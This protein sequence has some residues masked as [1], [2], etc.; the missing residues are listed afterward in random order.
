KN[1]LLMVAENRGPK[2]NA[3]GA[4]CALR[5]EYEDGTDE[6]IMTDTTWEV[7]GTMP[8]GSRPNQWKLD[9]LS[10]TDPVPV[11]V[12][13]WKT[14]TD[15]R[16][17]TTL[18]RA[19]AGS[20]RLIRASLLKAD[21]L[22]RALG[23]PNRDQIVTSRPAELTTLEAVHLATSD[24]LVL[25]LEEGAQR[26]AKLG[27]TTRLVEEIYLSTLSRFPTASEES[28]AREALG[29]APR[30]ESITD[31]LWALAMTPEFLIVR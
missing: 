11:H 1:T 15:K 19:S 16:I 29:E 17:G 31:L 8:P 4:F 13:Q 9:E 30:V 20:S 3:A 2:P 28:F 14:A 27:S 12:P 24:E 7:S 26:F 6:V 23:R 10:W 18:A 5:I 25:H 22:M 21:D